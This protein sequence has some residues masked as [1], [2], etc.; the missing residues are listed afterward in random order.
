M[1]LVDDKS[2]DNSIT[3]INNYAKC[4]DNIKSIFLEKNTGNPSTPRNVG[5]KHASAHYMMFVDADD[6]L[7]KDCC[8]NVYNLIVGEDMDI[9]NFK[10]CVKFSD[11]LYS[12]SNK[13]LSHNLSFEFFT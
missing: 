4:Y 12:Y 3:V 13:G 10:H 9:V 6:C 1:I 5:M 11:G 8:E 7:V 2:N